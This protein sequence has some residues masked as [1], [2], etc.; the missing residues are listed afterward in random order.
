MP[1]VVWEQTQLGNLIDL[2]YGRALHTGSRSD[3]EYPVIGSSGVV[4]KHHNYLTD[5]PALIVGRKGTVGTVIWSDQPCWPIDTT[6]WVQAKTHFSLRWLYWFLTCLDLE[7]HVLTT[8]VPGMSRHHLYDVAVLSPPFSEQRRIAEILDATDDHILAAQNSLEKLKRIGSGLLAD[9]L[10]PRSRTKLPRGWKSMPLGAT[11]TWLSGGTPATDNPRWWGGEIPWISASSLRDFWIRDSDRCVT[12]LGVLAGTRT[13]LPGAVLFVVRGMSLKNELRVGVAQRKVAF[14]QDCKAIVPAPGI[15]G[16]FLA[17]SIIA[18]EPDVLRMV[19]EAG[20]GTGRLPTD[21]ISQL[22][23]EIP[24]LAEQQRTV[25][26]MA[27]VETRMSEARRAVDKLRLLKT[28][29]M[30]DLLTGRVR[31]TRSGSLRGE[32][33]IRGCRD[34]RGAE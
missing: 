34:E 14:G 3:G 8:G 17:M 20:H 19:D 15:D 28:G 24:P 2:K 23:I 6:F 33:R 30:E 16:A 12:D 1:D 22:E 5:G 13:V 9:R 18:R 4:G 10:R 27:A 7:C 26:I 31:V 11:G 21:L 32:E 25:E 29:L